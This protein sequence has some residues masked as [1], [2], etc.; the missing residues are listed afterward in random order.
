VVLLIT[1][2]LIERKIAA[3]MLD[4]SLFRRWTFSGS[5]LSA[6][7]NYIC[8]YTITFLMPFYLLQGR[9][10]SP[11][12]TGM[13]LTSMP[14]AMAIVAPISG[15]ISDRIGTR[16]P[17]VIGMLILSIGLV[18]LSRLSAQ[19][20]LSQISIRLAIAG[21]GTGIFFYPNT[22]ALMGAAPR[23]RQGIAAGILATS[24]NVGMVL[25]VGLSGAIL[26]TVLE[27]H[28]SS[29]TSNL[30]LALQISFFTAAAIAL[31]GLLLS[32]NKT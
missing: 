5:V 14:I 29:S 10:F 3:P 32:W 23:T 16:W 26:T 18:L 27:Q 1:F 25:G 15:A 13:L 20:S 12:Q 21:L 31:A 6:I 9:H 4:L 17:T 8:V 11:T 24:R 30:F 22:S 7:F 19:S 2:V 28:S